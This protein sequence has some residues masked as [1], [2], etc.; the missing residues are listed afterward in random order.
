MRALEDDKA[1]FLVTAVENYLRCL[2]AGDRHDLR[3][4]RLTSLWFSNNGKQDINKLIRV[5]LYTGK[6]YSREEMLMRNSHDGSLHL[7]PF[8]G[9]IILT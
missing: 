4:F 9:K 8:T 2:K 1:R 5:I 3:V 7:A 6:I